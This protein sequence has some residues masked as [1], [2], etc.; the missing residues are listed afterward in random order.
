MFFSTHSRWRYTARATLGPFGLGVLLWMSLALASVPAN[1]QTDPSE[2][3]RVAEG[4]YEVY[5]PSDAPAVGPTVPGVFHFHESWTLWRLPEGTFEI[6]GTREYAS[7]SDE[8]H[9]DLFTLR[10]SSDFRIVQFREFR[11]LRWSPDSGP[12]ECDFT[13]ARLV[14][15]SG[16]VDPAKMIRLDV[17][18][19]SPYG[20]LWPISAFSLGHI[21]RFSDHRAKT[22]MPV[23][24]VSFEEPSI[25]DPVF[26]NVLGGQLTYMGR[27]T[28]SVAGRRWEADKFELKVALHTPFLIWTSPSGL[29]LDFARE[30]SHGRTQERGMKLIRYKE[31]SAF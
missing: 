14:C 11:K 12:L 18:M 10:L 26:A 19:E 24:M 22:A 9:K 29:L 2:K 16:A 7:P 15:T 1:G 20:F 23:E 4:E 25:E 5:V 3:V 13:T 27:E 6:Q 17:P 31:W 28:I 21:T 30:D 8:P